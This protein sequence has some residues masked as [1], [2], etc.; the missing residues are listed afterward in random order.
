MNDYLDKLQKIEELKYIE[1]IPNQLTADGIKKEVDRFIQ[2][3]GDSDFESV[4][5]FIIRYV[6]Q[7]SYNQ[8]VEDA[9]TILRSNSQDLNTKERI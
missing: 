7:D 8:G 4:L 9:L 5:F 2:I 3:T 6:G 1:R